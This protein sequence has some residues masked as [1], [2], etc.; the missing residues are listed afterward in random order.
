[1][2]LPFGKTDGGPNR[3]PAIGD[4][5]AVALLDGLRQRILV[6]A[7]KQLGQVDLEIADGANGSAGNGGC[8]VIGKHDCLLRT[9]PAARGATLL[10]IVLI[11]DGKPF[12]L[13]D[14][15]DAEEAEIDALHAIGATA[16]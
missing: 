2:L 13:I 8:L 1:S 6:G 12:V 15:I 5:F 3:L 7:A 9:D 11:F 4:K 16:V 10:A 14:A